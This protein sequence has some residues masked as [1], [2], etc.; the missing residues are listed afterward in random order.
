[1]TKE[2]ES[3]NTIYALAE[4]NCE[5]NSPELLRIIK[6]R[7][8]IV[9]KALLKVQEL[10]KA[11]ELIEKMYKYPVCFKYDNK[12][13]VEDVIIDYYDDAII[14]Y[15]PKTNEIEIYGYEFLTSYKVE[16]YGKTWW[17][18]EDKSE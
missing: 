17:L 7:N 14:L 8:E 1:M 9:I 12:E 6:D 11:F 2:L 5:E 13:S 4:S 15:N 10:E 18:K 16:E 3:Y